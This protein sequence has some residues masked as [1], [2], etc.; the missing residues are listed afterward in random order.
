MGPTLQGG[1]SRTSSGIHRLFAQDRACNPGLRQG[2]RQSTA[3]PTTC[4]YSSAAVC[5]CA[6]VCR[7][8]FAWEQART[9][10][11]RGGSRRSAAEQATCLR[12]SAAACACA[13]ELFSRPHGRPICQVRLH[14]GGLC[15]HG[16]KG[17]TDCALDRDTVCCRLRA[18]PRRIGSRGGRRAEGLGAVAGASSWPELPG[19]G[20]WGFSGQRGVVVGWRLSGVA[21]W[22]EG[23]FPG[24]R[25]EVAWCTYPVGGSTPGRM[26]GEASARG[27]TGEG[28]FMCTSPDV[29]FILGAVVTVQAGHKTRWEL[30][31]ANADFIF[32]GC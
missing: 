16:P 4:L 26:D 1:G 13:D 10:G 17:R 9:S 28:L 21:T 27:A 20:V 12:L 18:G 19:G 15:P 22:G 30:G 11:R 3:G 7:H 25:A 6:G 23:A 5:A 31:A 32:A 24:V 14:C 2:P 29:G 8:L